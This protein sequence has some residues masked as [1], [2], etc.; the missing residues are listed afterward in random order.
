M[1]ASMHSG[2]SVGRLPVLLFCCCQV[3]CKLCC[4]RCPPSKLLAATV[5]LSDQGLL[6]S[7][8][9]HPFSSHPPYKL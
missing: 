3:Q 2:C 7:I 8:Q 5:E 9:H 6:Y 1:S 4:Q